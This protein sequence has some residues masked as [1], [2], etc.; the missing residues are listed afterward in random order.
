MKIELNGLSLK[1]LEDL[2]VELGDKKFRA[3]QIFNYIHKN[4]GT[5][6]EEI[7]TISK[8]LRS[9]LNEASFINNVKIYEK[10]QSEID[11]TKKYLYL[12]NDG[13][14]IE[15]VAMEYKH[16]TSICIST[17]VGCRMNCSFC[18]STKDGLIRNLTPAEMISEIYTIERDLDKNISNIV[19]MGSG[20]PLDNYDN[21]VKFLKLINDEKGRNISA[22][23]ITLSTCGVVP[24]IYD[25][26]DEDI[27]VT[28]AIS[29]HSAYDEK[30]KEIM[31]I[32]KKYSIDEI[33]EAC[34]YYNGKANRRIT[35]EYT[36]IE[37]INDSMEDAKKLASL[38]GDLESHLN[39]I[40]LNP[41]KEY[42]QINPSDSHIAKFKKQLEK[43]GVKTTV[44]REMGRDISASCGQL[45]RSII[46]NNNI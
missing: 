31:P 41:I 9:K 26:A 40:P 30:R 21:V 19:L 17:Q 14:I 35:F 3:Q 12:L 33:L 15:A 25:L 34:R 2:V 11:D 32:S 13:N 4:K 10:Y 36:L 22:R 23:S 18:A 42:K 46:E 37:G 38:F 27:P 29:L 5:S 43:L 44:R 8:E 7:Q 1:E 45:R 28:L 39:L 16:G 24:K 20:E 6:I